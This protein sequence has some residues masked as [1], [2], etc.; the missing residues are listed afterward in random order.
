MKYERLAGEAPRSWILVFD[1][2]D[3]VSEGLLAFAREEGI[4]G[5]SFTA[6][7]A[8]QEATLAFFDLETK[9]YEE[10]PVRE[11]VE[12]LTLAG[13]VAV[14]E[15]EPR[16]HAHVVVGNRDGTARGGHLLEARVRPTL[17]VVVRET[18]AALRRRMDAET[19]LPL[20]DAGAGPPGGKNG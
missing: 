19:G 9:E 13:N 4:E 12:V 14:H 3:E 5:A 10:I 18:A 11:Q 6:I 1:T 15:G 17:E 20:L 16:V 7:G 2:G 8:F